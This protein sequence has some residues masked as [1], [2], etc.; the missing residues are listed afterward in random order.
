MSGMDHDGMSGEDMPGMMA[1][2]DMNGLKAS[3]GAEFDQMFLT[4]MIEHHEG[5]IEMAETEQ[6]EGQNPDAIALAKQIVAD[7][8]AE[9]QTMRALLES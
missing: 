3:T 1:Q 7:Q 8:Q 4:M 2:E 5:A 9:I 6:T